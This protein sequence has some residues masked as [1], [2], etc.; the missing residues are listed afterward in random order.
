MSIDFKE[1]SCQSELNFSRLLGN[2]QLSQRSS[3]LGVGR[4]LK[5]RLFAETFLKFMG[6]FQGVVVAQKFI[7]LYHI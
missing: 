3:S 2:K 5:F 6:L 7:K 4:R 1:G